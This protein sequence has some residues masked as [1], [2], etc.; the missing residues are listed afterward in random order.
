MQFLIYAVVDKTT[1]KIVYVGRTRRRLTVR[2]T[3]HLQRLR[4]HNHYN[5]VLQSAFDDGHNLVFIE[6]RWIEGEAEAIA[7]ERDAQARNGLQ[8]D[9]TAR[10]YDTCTTTRG[11]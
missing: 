2:K 9:T 8:Q 1:D 4:K 5:K 6:L 10:R 7:Y 11:F 3:A